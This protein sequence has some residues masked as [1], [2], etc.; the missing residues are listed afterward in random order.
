[1]YGGYYLPKGTLVVA[2]TWS[3]QSQPLTT[4]QSPIPTPLPSL[5]LPLLLPHD[6]ADLIPSLRAILHDAKAYPSPST[7]NP[8]RFLRSDGTPDPT[9]R[10]PSVAAFGFGRRICPGRFMAADAMWLAIACVLS[11]FDIRKA[12]GEDGREITPHGEYHRGF[13]WC[14]VCYSVFS[15]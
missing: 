2:N 11:V 15:Q 12:V 1:M 13:L 3:V 7:Y 5:P 6:H 9:V 10:D 8:D 14:V 4:H